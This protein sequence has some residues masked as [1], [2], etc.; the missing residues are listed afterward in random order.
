MWKTPLT[1]R[2]AINFIASII[3][4]C[5]FGLLIACTVGVMFLIGYDL[6]FGVDWATKQFMQT[7]VGVGIMSLVAGV[8]FG[9]T[10]GW[11]E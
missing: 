6:A 2:R 4:V 7:S 9:A 8:V 3:A 5:A 1:F 11:T 10:A